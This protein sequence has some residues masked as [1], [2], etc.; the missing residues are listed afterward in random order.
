MLAVQNIYRNAA[1][2]AFRLWQQISTGTPFRQENIYRYGV[3]ARSGTTTPLTSLNMAIRGKLQLPLKCFIACLWL[4]FE[5]V[6]N[7]VMWDWAGPQF[8]TDLVH[9]R[10]FIVKIIPKI[11]YCVQLLHDN[12]IHIHTKQNYSNRVTRVKFWRLCINLAELARCSA[13][14]T[15]GSQWCFTPMSL[16][17]SENGDL[18]GRDN[19][20]ESWIIPTPAILT[21]VL[22]RLFQFEFGNTDYPS[23]LYLT[24]NATRTGLRWRLNGV[25]REN[26]YIFVMPPPVG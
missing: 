22:R 26:S 18:W 8:L 24:L 4:D 1:V 6:T 9:T 16:A 7:S 25:I 13:I 20:R 12:R 17:C 10:L 19:S 5:A 2:L 11:Y 23:P 14:G 15:N 3:P 21:L